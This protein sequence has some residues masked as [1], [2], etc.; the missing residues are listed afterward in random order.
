MV[1]LMRYTRTGPAAVVVGLDCITG[2]QTARILSDRGI[3][4]VGVAADP[5]HFACRTRACDELVVADVT[6][7]ELIPALSRL[8]GGLDER[9]VLFP[10]TDQSVMLISQHRAELEGSYH[11]VLPEHE[12]V[13]LLMDK[14]R[15]TRFA[16][17]RGIPIPPTR[18]VST[19]EDARRAADALRFPVVV[20]PALKTSVWQAQR[21]AKVYRAARPARLLE[22]FHELSPWTDELIVQEWIEGTDADLFSCN[23][24]F[25]GDGDPVTAFVA[26]KLRQWPPEA[27]TSSLGEEI[28]NDEVLQDTLR[29][30]QG[31]GY[32]GLGYVEFKRDAVSGR[33]YMIE[34]NVGRPTGRSAIAEAGGVELL[35][36]MYRDAIGASL[37]AARTQH[38]VG[39]KWI[40]FRHDLQSALVYLVRGKLTPGEWRRSWSGPKVDAVWSR[41]DV[42]PFFWDWWQAFTR[43][44]LPR[45]ARPRDAGD[46]PGRPVTGVRELAGSAPRG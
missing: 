13:E 23:C 4:V 33:S 44:S 35:Y 40:Y 5:R 3:R 6:G 11:V 28:R 21:L 32:R 22:L 20:K 45:R 46:Q 31:V 42:A 17:A 12:T 19:E 8:G 1:R 34:P 2:L 15:F 9:A 25:G 18:F 30:F 43:H 39:A 24:Y 36:S 29:L 16:Q 10:C 38:Y 14:A 7:H 26:R 27:G 37:P 41:S